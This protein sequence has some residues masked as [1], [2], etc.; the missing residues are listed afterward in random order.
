MLCIGFWINDGSSTKAK[1]YRLSL[2]TQANTNQKRRDKRRARISGIAPSA[3]ENTAGI[4]P[5]RS[6]ASA[7]VKC[8]HPTLPLG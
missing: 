5:V 4:F 6:V 3:L 7:A 2:Q 1:T 8:Y